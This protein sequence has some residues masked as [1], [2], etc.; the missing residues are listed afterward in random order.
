M[1]I[2]KAQEHSQLACW[3]AERMGAAVRLPRPNRRLRLLQTRM[4]LA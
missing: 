3:L 4:A 2:Q 1:I